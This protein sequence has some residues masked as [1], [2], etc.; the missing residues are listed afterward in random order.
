MSENMR[1]VAFR[2]LS[3]LFP[4]Q[5]GI[6]YSRLDKSPGPLEFR[7]LRSLIR[8]KNAVKVEKDSRKPR[9]LG[10]ISPGEL[11]LHRR[12]LAFTVPPLGQP[13]EDEKLPAIRLLWVAH[14]KDF[15]VLTHSL[16]SALAHTRN[17]VATITVVS[18]EPTQA[19]GALRHIIPSRISADFRHDNDFVP[20]EVRSQLDQALPSHGSWATQQL[21]KVLA[22]MEQQSSATLVID[23]DTVLLQSKTWLSSGGIQLLY[24]RGFHNDRYANFLRHWGFNEIDTMRSFVT[25]HMLFQPDILRQAM[26]LTFGSLNIE[27][28]V[29]K[30][31]GSVEA[32]GYPEFCLEYEP[33]GQ[34]ISRKHRDLV[35]LDKYSNIGLPTPMAPEALTGQIMRLRSHGHFN[36]VSFHRPDR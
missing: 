31:I 22:T 7:V 11:R 5:W 8:L 2:V 4:L 6:K 29:E 9:S 27:R 33:Y 30:V 25:H 10:A 13:V 21:I 20:V 15:P 17:P 19:E 16:E 34:L 18:P 23:A 32:L 36:S 26:M 35:S 3:A 14:P 24:F 1:Q 28:I 12:Y